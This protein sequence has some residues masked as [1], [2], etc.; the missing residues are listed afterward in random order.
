MDKV[1]R[2]AGRIENCYLVKGDYCYLVDTATRM[3]SKKID[4][5]FAEEKIKPEDLT[6]IFITH[7][8]A[9]HTWGNCFFPGATIVSHSLCR[10]LMR[11]KGT[12]S[13]EAAKKQNN[14][15]RQVKIVLPH[16]T[17]SNGDLNLRV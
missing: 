15:L 3:T 12:P 14:A 16:L 5:A 10:E 4:Q 13:L 1:V 11:E 17:F 6:H 8:H 7:Y 2:I 9:D